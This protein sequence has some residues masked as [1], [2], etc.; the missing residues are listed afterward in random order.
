MKKHF[1]VKYIFAAVSFL[2]FITFTSAGLVFAAAPSSLK[3][4]T[5]VQPA[6]QPKVETD[7]FN[8]N[9][10]KLK[11][12]DPF[13]RRQ[14]AEGLGN[15]RDQRAIPYLMNA[16][17]DSSPLVRQSAVDALGLMRAAQ[18]VKQIGA[19]LVGDKEPQVRQSAAVALGYIGGS[20]GQPYL[21]KALADPVAGVKYSAAA[22]LGQIRSPEAVTALQGA[23]SDSDAGM[24]RSVLVA[25]D[26]SEDSSP[27][28]AVR[29]MLNDTDPVVRALAAKFVGK[30]KDA[31]ARAQLQEMLKD[32]DNRAVIAAA[33]SLGRI[34]D[35]SGLSAV[36]KIVK[37][38][39][40]DVTA[41][42]M[43]IEALEAIAT[44]QAIEIIKG[45]ASD[46]DEYVKTSARYALIRM[47]VPPESPATKGKT[48][49]AGTSSSHNK[50][51]ISPQKESSPKK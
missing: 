38:P 25:L 18:S 1:A 42:T 8:L 34:G 50:N 3:E 31:E 13:V 4:E 28:P 47:K 12:K 22:S 33:Y 14:G 36:S 35:H 43:A 30:F 24:R 23:L 11:D 46:A 51:T 45:L 39:D 16:L 20:E 48:P 7:P 26:R 6:G 40:S 41:K 32:T 9:I 21:I 15:L 10:T 17:N 5:S 27:L 29:S 37:S 19:L 44:P 2:F 49:A